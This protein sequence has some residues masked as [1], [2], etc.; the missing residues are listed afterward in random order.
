LATTA[1]ESDITTGF[2]AARAGEWSA[3]DDLHGVVRL[4]RWDAAEHLWLASGNLTADGAELHLV[5]GTMIIS[6]ALTSIRLNTPGG[7][8]TFDAGEARI[9]Y[10]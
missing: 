4:A 6:E 10:R 3:A 8:A 2:M 1:G 7:T 9:R 5:A